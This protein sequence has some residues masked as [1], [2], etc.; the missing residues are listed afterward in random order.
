MYQKSELDKKQYEVEKVTEYNYFVLREDDKYG[1]MDKQAN[2]IIKPSYEN[3]IIPNPGK[4]VF[5]CYDESEKTVVLNE[6]N[7]NIYTEFE[8]VEPIRLKN[9]L[10]DLM[11]EKSIL[12]FKK[13]GKTG[14]ITL[15]GK[16]IVKPNYDEITGLPYKEGEVIVKQGDN[17]GVINRNGA[18]LLEAKYSKIAI[19]E[20]Y[21]EEVG[22]KKSGYIVQQTTDEGYRY[23]YIDNNFNQMMNIEYNEL[24]R[25]IDLEG[26]E[27]IY[28]IAAKNGQFGL[29]RNGN[30]VIENSYQSI[31]YD[32]TNHIFIIEKS[33]KY[34]V[35]SIEGNIIIPVEYSQI[36][37]TGKYIYA[38]KNNE[39]KV[40]DA[41]GKTANIDSTT[42][43]LETS[44]PNYKIKM[45]SNE[46]TLYGIIDNNN[47]ELVESKYNYI[48]YLFN[49]YFIASNSDGK[50]GVINDKGEEIVSLENDSVQKVTNN[51][52]VQVSKTDEPGARFYS[53]SME[54][55]C[56]IENPIIEENAEYIKVYNTEETF[57]LNKEG[58][59]LEYSEIA[60]Q[61]MLYAKKQNDKWGYVDSEGKTKIDYIYDKVTDFNKYGFA[62][63]KK[64]DKWG[65]I[66]SQGN[67]IVG[68][69][70]TIKTET[71]PF[72]IG[73][74]YRVEYGYGENYYTK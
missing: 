67:I 14:L 26:S 1:V 39:T 65:V 44:N 47:K 10:S 22:Y 50:L 33:K 72:F 36:D 43:I 69:S 51:K 70:Y 19:D 66:D 21:D 56:E 15:D 29:Y 41:Q 58:Q 74:Y 4:P 31:R 40:F 60:P 52:I 12:T 45:T 71:E 48:D 42:E 73:E 9:I 25:V 49:N 27:K 2:I 24:S 34:G 17:Y 62:G 61:N 20:Y 3:V 28:I 32:K 6:K 18:V 11:Y 63:I 53:N 54:L 30:Q 16:E 46:E 59:Q 55:I 35:A 13:D 37:I 64:D 23:G 5:I 38:Q 8:Q 57:Y 68:P 7:E